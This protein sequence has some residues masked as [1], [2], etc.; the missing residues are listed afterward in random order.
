MGTH[1]HC[2]Q[3]AETGCIQVLDR[4]KC[5][6]PHSDGM[7]TAVALLYRARGQGSMYVGMLCT[8]A[9]KQSLDSTQPK[10]HLTIVDHSDV[11]ITLPQP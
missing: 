9:S 5:S 11:D 1:Q 8:P 10:A 2:Q 3:C 6:V 4:L 7:S